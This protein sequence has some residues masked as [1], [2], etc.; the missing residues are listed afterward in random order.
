M[1]AEAT[2]LARD[3]INEPANLMTPSRV[4][5]VARSVASENSVS[6]ACTEGRD[7]EGGAERGFSVAA[8]SSVV[9]DRNR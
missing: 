7:I 3:M 1:I 5:E 4:A 2:C 6:V 9:S 8:S